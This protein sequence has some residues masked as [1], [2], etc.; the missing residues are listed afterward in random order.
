MYDDESMIIML[1]A[2]IAV[3]FQ[4][5]FMNIVYPKIDFYVAFFLC[6]SHIIV[7]CFVAL[8]PLI[9][10]H[11]CRIYKKVHK[12]LIWS[13]FS[14][15]LSSSILQITF[16]LLYIGVLFGIWD[17]FDNHCPFKKFYDVSYP[18]VTPKTKDFVKI[19]FLIQTIKLIFVTIE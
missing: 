3:G 5:I 13:I 9:A 16:C 15:I 18:E 4:L 11:P 17:I 8:K 19:L 14:S 7:F 6:I 10:K 12:L 2:S 1:F